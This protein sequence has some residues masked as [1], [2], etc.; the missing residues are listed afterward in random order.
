[1]NL[2]DRCYDVYVETSHTFDGK[3]KRLVSILD[4]ALCDLVPVDVIDSL[5]YEVGS[6]SCDAERHGFNAGFR[7]GLAHQILNIDTEKLNASPLHEVVTPTG[8]DVFTGSLE[9]CREY[10]DQAITKGSPVGFLTIQP[11]TPLEVDHE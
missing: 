4:T 9:E 2:I 7:F 8:T 6:Y 10:L 1:M 3:S 11:A 5:Q